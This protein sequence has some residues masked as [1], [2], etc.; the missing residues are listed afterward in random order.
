MTRHLLWAASGAWV[1]L[2][3]IVWVLF[4]PKGLSVGTY[5]LLTLTGPLFLIAAARRW[6]TPRPAHSAQPPRAEAN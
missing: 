2:M 6:N 4:V 5:T 3:A 1:V